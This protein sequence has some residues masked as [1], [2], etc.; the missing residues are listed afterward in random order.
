MDMRKE[1]NK[2]VNYLSTEFKFL[3]MLAIIY[4]LSTLH[5]GKIIIFYTY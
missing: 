3:T 1:T 2:K 5:P 4:S